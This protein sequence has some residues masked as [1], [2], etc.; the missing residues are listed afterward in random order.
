MIII[1]VLLF[2]FTI[3]MVKNKENWIHR[4]NINV[5]IPRKSLPVNRDNQ[6][7]RVRWAILNKARLSRGLSPEEFKALSAQEVNNIIKDPLLTDIARNPQRT[8]TDEEMKIVME[9]ISKFDK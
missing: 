7:E 8:C 2:M 3:S 5:L 6:M 9:K 1:F 4:H